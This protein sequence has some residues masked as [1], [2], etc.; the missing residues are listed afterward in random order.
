[1][2]TP[3]SSARRFLAI[4]IPDSLRDALAAIAPAPASGI[5]PVDVHGLHLTLHFLGD[6]TRE[7]V[8]AALSGFE[9]PSFEIVLRGAG[10]FSPPTGDTVL[11]IGIQSS[12]ALLQVHQ[13]LGERLRAA[14]LKTESRPYAPHLT[15]AR[16]AARVDKRLINDWL[17]AW[18]DFGPLPSPVPSVQ[19]YRSERVAGQAPRYVVE[20][21]W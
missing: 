3:R 13:D 5:R 16:C 10:Q 12:A 11:W 8:E 9:M 2:S 14:G 7:V 20:T 18:Q 15:L 19:L 1:V 4:P 21:A 6:V 17:D